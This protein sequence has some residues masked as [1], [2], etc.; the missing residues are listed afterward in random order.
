MYL[1]DEVH[2]IFLVYLFEYINLI[3]SLKFENSDFGSN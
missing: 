3:R 1:Y 2:C